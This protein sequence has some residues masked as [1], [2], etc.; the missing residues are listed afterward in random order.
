MNDKL[1]IDRNRH[2]KLLVSFIYIDIQFGQAYKP[3]KSCNSNNF[4]YIYIFGI[5]LYILFIKYLYLTLL[6]SASFYEYSK[7][8][9]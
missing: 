3:P 2:P 7:K 1:S 5:L 6:F 9:T 4:I 8:N